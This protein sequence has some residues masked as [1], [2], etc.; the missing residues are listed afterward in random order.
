MAQRYH[1]KA[2]CP[3]V[4]IMQSGPLELCDAAFLFWSHIVSV[5]NI[6]STVA[7][8]MEFIS[9]EHQLPLLKNET[10]TCPVF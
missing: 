9:F 8:G 1:P 5:Q 10:N 6:N 2:T 4:S 3:M 7:L